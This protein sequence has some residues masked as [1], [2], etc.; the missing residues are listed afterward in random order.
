MTIPPKGTCKI[1]VTYTATQSGRQTGT[2]TI[3]SDAANNPI[4]VKLQGAGNAARKPTT[5]GSTGGTVQ[6]ASGDSVSIPAGTFSSS[7]SVAI[8]PIP[9]SSIEA[10]TGQ[11]LSDEGLDFLG[12][13]S[14]DAGAATFNNRL[15]LTVPNRTGLPDGTNVLVTQLLFEVNGGTAA[16]LVDSPQVHGGVITDAAPFFPG[17]TGSGIFSVVNPRALWALVNTRAVNS[18]GLPAPNVLVGEV[19]SY[20]LSPTDA[21]GSAIVTF[22]T[23]VTNLLLVAADKVFSSFGFHT[24]PL[25]GAAAPPSIFAGNTGQPTGTS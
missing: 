1:K 9:Q 14:L 12:A 13:V 11:N 2:L 5:I 25:A 24:F 18:T 21:A 3:P 23:S 22:P 10:L 20:L 17:V 6:D 4:S 19:H 15:S 7:T 16:I 8:S